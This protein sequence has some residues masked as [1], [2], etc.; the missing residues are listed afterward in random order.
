[1]ENAEG[2]QREELRRKKVLT[3]QK[4]KNNW[5]IRHVL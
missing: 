5:V 3:L 4:K 1:M 2:M